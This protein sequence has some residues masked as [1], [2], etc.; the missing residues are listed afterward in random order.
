M[1]ERQSRAIPP[2]SGKRERHDRVEVRD[3]GARGRG[4]FAT[5]PLKARR[6]VGRV[7]GEIMPPDFR[8]DYCVEFGDAVLEPAAPYRFM[9]HS[10][11]PNCEFVE[12]SIEDESDLDE[13]GAPRVTLELWVHAIRDLDVG[14]ELLIDYGWDWQAAIPCLCGAPNC[15]GWIC[16]PEDLERCKER[17]AREAQE[18]RRDEP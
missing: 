17:Y 10:C 12:W 11:D 1:T 16:K 14:E 18:S 5:A 2:F 6:A 7:Y 4:L 3:A 15:R 9:N 8:S 13:N